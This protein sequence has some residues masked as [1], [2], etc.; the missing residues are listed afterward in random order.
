MHFHWHISYRV[1]A[2]YRV[3]DSVP[4]TSEQACLDGIKRLPWSKD[5][6]PKPHRLAARF[7]QAC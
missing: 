2:G 5:E 3:L 6:D 4:Y 1:P 7:C